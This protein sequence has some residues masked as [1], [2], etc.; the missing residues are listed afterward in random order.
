MK[1]N[2]KGFESSFTIRGVRYKVNV[3]HDLADG[4]GISIQDAFSTWFVRTKVYTSE[5]F[6]QYVKDKLPDATCDPIEQ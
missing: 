3:L 5:S 2:L 1:K 4:F 6:C